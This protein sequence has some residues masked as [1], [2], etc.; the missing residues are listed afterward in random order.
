MKDGLAPGLRAGFVAAATALPKWKTGATVAVPGAVALGN[1]PKRKG[2]AVEVVVVVAAVA[3][4]AAVVVLLG[5]AGTLSP[6]LNAGLLAEAGTV[7]AGADEASGAEAA[8]SRP[9]KPDAPEA[10]QLLGV[11]WAGTG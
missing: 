8:S 5:A 6:K 2:W 9:G 11:L 10:G 4:A 7:L 1:E 3:A